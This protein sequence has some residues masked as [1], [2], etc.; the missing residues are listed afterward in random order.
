MATGDAYTSS[1]MA[2]P[3][4][5][6]PDE[7]SPPPPPTEVADLR[8]GESYPSDPSHLGG[9]API[10]PAEPPPMP[11]PQSVPVA[12]RNPTEGGGWWSNFKSAITPSPETASRMDRIGNILTSVGREGDPFK[13][14]ANNALK[15]QAIDTEAGRMQLEA[16]QNPAKI[17]ALEA[18][19]TEAQVAMKQAELQNAQKLQ[20]DMLEY[21]MKLENDADA[22]TNQGRKSLW[23]P[24]QNLQANPGAP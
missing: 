6:L 14:V 4:S 21:Y 22:K 1:A 9:P 24:R 10:H 5:M 18:Q 17:K 13:D 7:L 8:Y 15:Q 11:T 16:A 20:R 3:S 19:S 12:E 2:R 23:R